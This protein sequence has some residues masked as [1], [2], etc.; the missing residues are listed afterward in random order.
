MKTFDVDVTQRLEITV[1][2]TKFTEE[3]FDEFTEYFFPY[4]TI[5][6]HVKHIAQL[7]ARGVYQGS[8][9]EFVEGYGKIDE[10]FGVKVKEI[11]CDETL[12]D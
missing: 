6:E 7:Y 2:E 1:D 12:W 10:E 11:Y 8:R 5:E 4:D 3:F 9:G